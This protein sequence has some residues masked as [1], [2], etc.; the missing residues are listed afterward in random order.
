[1]YSIFIP[2]L[3]QLLEQEEVLRQQEVLRLQL[4]QQ[5]LGFWLGI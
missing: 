1:M 5:L 2:E 3:Q 4:Q